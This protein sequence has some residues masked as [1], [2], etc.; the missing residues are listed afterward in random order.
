[1]NQTASTLQ[2][3]DIS[4][5]D[6]RT[7][8]AA[9]SENSRIQKALSLP[10]RYQPARLALSLSLRKSSVPSPIPDSGGRTI[11]GDTLFGQDEADLTL[12]IALIVQHS[13][14]TQLSR[15]AFQ[16]LVAAHWARGMEMFSR[17]IVGAKTIEEAFACLLEM[18]PI[19]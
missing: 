15:R 5:A 3:G 14:Q 6:F 8:F 17:S 11:K 16:D 12:W 4:R 2:I 7:S 13:G 18:K 10:F 9:D 19:R 1:M